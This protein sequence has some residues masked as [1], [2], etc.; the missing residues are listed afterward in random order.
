LELT[1]NLNLALPAVLHSEYRD[2]DGFAEIFAEKKL[3]IYK[4]ELLPFLRLKEKI[5]VECPNVYIVAGNVAECKDSEIHI[6]IE[7]IEIMENSEEYVGVNCDLIG[8]IRKLE[9]HIT[10]ISTSEIHFTIPVIEK[11]KFTIKVIFMGKALKL[12]AKTCPTSILFGQ[13]AKYKCEISEVN[14]RALLLN[15]ISHFHKIYLKDFLKD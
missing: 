1:A 11:D 15:I 9:C 3:I 8:N 12:K 5:W 10:Y 13:N 4:G 2:D 7:K 14:D 6:N